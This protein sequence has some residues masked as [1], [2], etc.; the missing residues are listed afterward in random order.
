[1]KKNFLVLISLA[2]AACGGSYGDNA[3]AVAQVTLSVQSARIEV[4]E[5]TAASAAA[6]DQNGAAFEGAIG[7]ASDH[8]E[9]AAVSPTTGAIFAVAPG[10]AAITATLGGKSAQQTVT[11]FTSPIRLNEI[12]S[13]G[14]A[15]TGWIEL[16]NPT[17]ADIDLSHWTVTASNV[18]ASFTLPEGTTIPAGGLFV[19]EETSFPEGLKGAD[20]VHVFSGFGV[21]VDSFA[22]TTPVA[23]GRCPNGTGDFIQ[24]NP[25]T[26]GTPNVCA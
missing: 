24:S 6:T 20:T 13:R 22:W 16:F 19:V 5:T 4:G 12:S 2:A 9:I 18:F 10:T 11:V 21:Q 17:A 15:S 23:F 25:V 3:P 7:F 14:D 1:M 8:P 26:K